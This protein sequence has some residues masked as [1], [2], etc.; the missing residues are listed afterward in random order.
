MVGKWHIGFKEGLRPHERGFDYF[1]GFHSGAHTYYSDQEDKN[2]L[3]RNDKTVTGE[4]DYL[5]DI[6][7]RESVAFIDRN[8]S[9]PF[10]LYLSFNAVHA[11]MEATSDYEKRFPHITDPDR[12]TYAGMTAAMDDAVGDVLATL[13]KHKMEENT[14]VFFYSDNGGPTAQTTSRND[15]LRGYKGNMYEGGVRVPFMVQ[16][17]GKL[18]A[19][20]VYREMVMGFDVHATAISAA[21]LPM[22]TEK[23]L[24]GVDLI[25]F[26]TGKKTGQPHES[27][28][29]RSGNRK[30]AV[31]VGD[32][33]LVQ[34]KAASQLFNLANDISESRNLAKAKPE[35]LR[36]LQ[37][38]YDA[39]DAEMM[40]P[41]WVR[42]DRENAKR[43][44]E[45]RTQPATA[46]KSGRGQIIRQRFEQLDR[47]GNG[48]LTGNE[49]E[50]S[51][52][53]RQAD[54]NGDGAVTL[55]E[56]REYFRARRQT[57]E[58]A[59]G[60]ESRSER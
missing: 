14:L 56:A 50:R 42:Q 12:K 18:P 46:G 4:K 43:G 52:A 23:P 51:Q 55:D 13:R 57:G 39:W 11:P 47:N 30:H 49:L 26:L 16:W 9:E 34:D 40:D 35:K 19:G 15:P 32:W 21:G 17:K 2:P 60:T 36:Q 59:G 29:W 53:L 7:A 41:Q 48:R 33:K 6:F 22:P 27:L 31:R 8:K 1:Y 3:I 58:Q 24:D 37:A 44:G 38:I 5:T 25:P 28:F 20:K 10:F 54:A 45:L